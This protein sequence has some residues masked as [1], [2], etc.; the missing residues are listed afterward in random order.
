MLVATSCLEVT[1]TPLE[2]P[3]R[4]GGKPA[5]GLSILNFQ[6]HCLFLH[7]AT[8]LVQECKGK[9]QRSPLTTGTSPEKKRT[10][11]FKPSCWVLFSF[12]EDRERDVVPRTATACL[13]R[14]HRIP[15]SPGPLAVRGHW[16][17]PLP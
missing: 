5:P 6:E 12:G 13:P 10:T 4:D 8:V 3:Q 7:P 2:T 14:L 16:D 1:S 17:A 11:D 15:L 9:T